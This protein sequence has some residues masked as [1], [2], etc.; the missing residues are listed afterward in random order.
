MK[1]TQKVDIA[2]LTEKVSRIEE[3]LALYERNHFPA[4]EARFDSIE[5]KLAFAGGGL[6]ILQLILKY[7]A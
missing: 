6:A 1:D 4:I 5:R 2:I 3:K 7:L